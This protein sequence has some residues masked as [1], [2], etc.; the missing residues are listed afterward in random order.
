[1]PISKFKESL[2]RPAGNKASYC[3]IAVIGTSYYGLQAFWT[4]AVT[5]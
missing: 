5:L 2:L 3:K 4:M 1:M